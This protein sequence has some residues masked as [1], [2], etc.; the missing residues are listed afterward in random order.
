MKILLDF[1]RSRYF[2]DGLLILTT[3]LNEMNPVY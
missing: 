1:G 2:W 3:F